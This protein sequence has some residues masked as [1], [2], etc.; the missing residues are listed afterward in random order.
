M[1][2][3]LL[4]VGNDIGKPVSVPPVGIFPGTGITTTPF[5]T[6]VNVPES[7]AAGCFASACARFDMAALCAASGS[8]SMPAAL[9]R[10][11]SVPKNS[12]VAPSR[13]PLNVKL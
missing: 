5:T 6:S 2:R 11:G 4:P 1:P 13:P 9:K 8:Y 10:M 12:G 3:S 7:F